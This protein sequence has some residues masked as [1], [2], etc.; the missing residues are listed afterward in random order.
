[1]LGGTNVDGVSPVIP[2]AMLDT[3][4]FIWSEPQIDN[5][6]IPKLVYH[7]ATLMNKLMVVAFGKLLYFSKKK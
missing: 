2:M 7:S 4:T 1:V 3:T 6:N 5:P